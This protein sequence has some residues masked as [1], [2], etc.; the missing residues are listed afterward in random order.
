[1]YFK[2][3]NMLYLADYHFLFS[4]C[5]VVKTCAF[6]MKKRFLKLFAFSIINSIIIAIFPTYIFFY[7]SILSVGVFVCIAVVTSDLLGKTSDWK[8]AFIIMSFG[9]LSLGFG[10]LLL[11]LRGV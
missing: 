3:K 11:L 7:F 8:G 4:K 10:Y 2:T 9:I 6:I 5:R 1:M